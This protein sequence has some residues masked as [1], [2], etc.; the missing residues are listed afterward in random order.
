VT[1]R[2]VLI[3]TL[4]EFGEKEWPSGERALMVPKLQEI[5]RTVADP[6]LRASAEWLLRQW[7]QEAWIKQVDGEW[8]KDKEQ[9]ERRIEGIK[10]VLTKEK[11]KAKPQWYV[12]GE[13]QTMVV[14]PGPVEFTM[15]APPTEEGAFSYELLHR[16]RIGRSFAIASK[17]VAVAEYRRYNQSYSITERYAP[18]PDCPA[19][20]TSWYDSAAYC[21]WLSKEEGP[22]QWC[23]E[24]NSHGQVM[25]LKE[26]YLHLTGYRLP[27]EAEMEYAT[28]AGALTSRYYGETEELLPK[29]AWYATN[30]K[31]R[32][33]PVGNLKPNDFG[34][35]D[36]HGN[37]WCW[38]QE[39][40]EDYPQVKERDVSDDIEDA[41]SIDNQNS[42]VLRG[43]S[44]GDPASHLRS[45][46]RD[47]YLPSVSDNIVGFRMARTI[48]AE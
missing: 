23:Y 17:P 13:G 21:N 26:K 48:S 32:T 9:R 4:G 31:E 3:L 44:F 42:R 38:C 46:D 6:G 19:L 36:M 20:G 37:V 39:Q 12:S 47:S 24:T 15:G 27:T 22:N 43:G 30:A 25:K 5:Y 7:K 28:R 40:F 8:A 29:Y 41:L 18:T 45:A 33:W 11:E 14:I 2:R 35:F 34:L 10:N 16:K 1:I